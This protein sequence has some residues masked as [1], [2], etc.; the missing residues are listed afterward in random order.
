M[1]L[2]SIVGAACVGAGI[3]WLLVSVLVWLA[4]DR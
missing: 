2:L 3:G 1:T 4:E